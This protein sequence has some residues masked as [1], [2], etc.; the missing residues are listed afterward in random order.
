M[1]KREPADLGFAAT[2]EAGDESD[3]IVAIPSP[4]SQSQINKLR[5]VA[6]SL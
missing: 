5:F 6:R 3:I 4:F 2:F 1:P